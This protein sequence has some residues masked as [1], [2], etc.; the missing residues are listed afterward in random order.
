MNTR[1]FRPSSRLFLCLAIVM[2]LAGCSSKPPAEQVAPPPTQSAHQEQD[3]WIR[4]ADPLEAFNRRVYRFNYYADEYVVLPIVMGY[5]K[6][7]PDVAE[8][9]VSNFIDNILELTNFSNSLLQLKPKAS[10]I[11]LGR[12]VTNTTV[13]LLGLFDPATELGLQRQDEDFGQTLGFYGVGNGPYLVLPLIGPTNLRDSLG[14]LGDNTLFTGVDPLNLDDHQTRE[15]VFKSLY[16]VDKRTRVP[17]R[18]YASGNP[19]EYE[20]VRFLYTQKRL[21]QIKE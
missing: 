21:L 2:L 8:K 5:R 7:M 16:G 18:Y 15:Y 1:R 3:H 9:G 4:V 20:W 17:F 13:G 19:F 6:V 10:L 12:F 14:M 11:T